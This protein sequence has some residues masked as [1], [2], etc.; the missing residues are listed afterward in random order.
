MRNALSYFITYF[1]QIPKCN[2]DRALRIILPSMRKLVY[3]LALALV[4]GLLA[5][6]S[7]ALA[8]QRPEHPWGFGVRGGVIANAHENVRS[9]F[10]HGRA[11]DAVTSG[12]ALDGMYDFTKL[13]GMRLSLSWGKNAG[14]AN[15][16][17]AGGG[18][19]PY[20][21]RS[22][23]VFADAMIHFGT[24]EDAFSS[25]IYG[26]LG[27]AYTYGLIEELKD[28]VTDWPHP[29]A[30]PESS[31]PM[32]TEPNSVFGFRVG[33]LGEWHITREV[34]ILVEACGEFYSDMY[35]CLKPAWDEHAPYRGYAGFPFDMRFIL[36][37]G[38]AYHF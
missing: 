8:Q 7:R 29:W 38:I 14:A 23:N 17:E 19:Y 28:G 12:F 36:S 11:I 13:F 32:A 6:G 20:L 37:L 10:N 9:Y 27:Y 16:Q 4:P 3:I 31:I 21:F 34:G 22:I 26:G 24:P 30:T 18:F 35:D 33:Y 5:P 25:R 15:S 2:H 1:Y